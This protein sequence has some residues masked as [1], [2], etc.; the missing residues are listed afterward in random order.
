MLNIGPERA[1]DG[2]M[3][4]ES[5]ERRLYEADREALVEATNETLGVYA[6]LAHSY[7]DTLARQHEILVS[8]DETLRRVREFLDNP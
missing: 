4:E 8:V 1:D 3:A 2:G 7:D 5:T 6:D